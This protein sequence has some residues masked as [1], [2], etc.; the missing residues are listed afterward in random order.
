[1]KIRELVQHW[2]ENAQGRLTATP[3]QIHLDLEAAARL[4]ALQEMYP[5][6]HV[7]ELLGELLGA[8]LDELEASLPYVKGSKVVATDARG[9]PLYE[10]IGLPPRFLALSRQHLQRI[11]QQKNGAG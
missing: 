10:D 1:M 9:D 2:Q 6:H 3:Y 7:E 5:K 8:A 4:A 11:S